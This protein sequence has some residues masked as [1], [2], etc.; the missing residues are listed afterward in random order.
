MQRLPPVEKKLTLVNIELS[1]LHS[2][3]GTHD[4]I[5]GTMESLIGYIFRGEIVVTL[6]LHNLFGLLISQQVEIVG[7]TPNR[8]CL[9]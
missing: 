9:L 2:L 7:F 4:L 6:L 5:K 8:Y 3:R 1:V